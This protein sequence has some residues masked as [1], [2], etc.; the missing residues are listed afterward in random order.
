M[1][2][3]CGCVGMMML[4]TQCSNWICTVDTQ[5]DYIRQRAATTVSSTPRSTS[6][7]GAA[8]IG[9]GHAS[10]EFATTSTE[11]VTGMDIVSTSFVNSYHSTEGTT[12]RTQG[13]TNLDYSTA[14]STSRG[15]TATEDFTTLSTT[16]SRPMIT[17]TTAPPSESTCSQTTFTL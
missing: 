9:A 13:V 16:T 2:M 15:T 7:A 6:T 14:S 11:T 4:M 10:T 1:I 8:A 5:K 12:S 3:A 17:T